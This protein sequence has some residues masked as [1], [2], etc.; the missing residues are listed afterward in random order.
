MGQCWRPWMDSWK[1]SSRRSS[2]SVCWRSRVACLVKVR[3]PMA[4]S[5]A[6]FLEMRMGLQCRTSE[7]SARSVVPFVQFGSEPRSK[8][9]ITFFAKAIS[10]WVHCPVR[11]GTELAGCGAGAA[12]SRWRSGVGGC[13]RLLSGGR[14]LSAVS[15]CGASCSC[16][17]GCCC[18]RAGCCVA[19]RGRC[20]SLVSAGSSTGRLTP[21]CCSSPSIERRRRR[22]HSTVAC[23]TVMH[24]LSEKHSRRL[25]APTLLVVAM[26]ALV[27]GRSQQL[28]A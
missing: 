8:Y 21:R 6:N 13:A 7:R 10:S 18:S 26:A 17:R 2:S 14:L 25:L 16:S 23:D 3:L 15:S 4:M 12:C 9:S 5:P 27:D 1:S 11:S 24:V 28:L 22:D 19:A 20:A